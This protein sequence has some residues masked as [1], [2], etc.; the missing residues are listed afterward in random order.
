MVWTMNVR[1]DQLDQS[2]ESHVS[3]H[4][5]YAAIQHY[6]VVLVA[7]HLGNPSGLVP[8]HQFR[9]S[10]ILTDDD[11]ADLQWAEI[12]KSAGHTDP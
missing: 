5:A 11:I 2:E 7:V 8:P 4:R 10:D 12:H 3:Q 1:G 6:D 9:T